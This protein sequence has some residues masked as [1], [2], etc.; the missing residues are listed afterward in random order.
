LVNR[1]KALNIF[2]TQHEKYKHELRGLETADFIKHATAPA[3]VREEKIRENIDRLGWHENMEL[4]DLGISV[5]PQMMKLDA[6]ILYPPVPQFASGTDTQPPS[7]GRWN[8][9]NKTFV[10]PRQ[11]ASW[12]IVYFVA[13]GRGRIRNEPEEVVV[14]RLEHELGRTLRNHSIRVQSRGIIMKA[15]MMGDSVKT[16]REFYHKCKA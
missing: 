11:L 5:H 1:E 9:R 4:R 14:Q 2:F 13:P 16:L 8:L 10:K 3:F 6:R 12:G 7:S 15:D